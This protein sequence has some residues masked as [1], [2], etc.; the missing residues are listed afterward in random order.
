MQRMQITVAVVTL[1][2][3]ALLAGA[4]AAHWPFWRRAWQWQ[5]AAEGWADTLPGPTV[6]IAAGGNHL[7][8]RIAADARL[9]ERVGGVRRCCWWGKPLALW[10][11]GSHPVR[12]ISR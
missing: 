5:T 8:L 10:P 6:R 12:T 2:V 3:V 9:A 11:H 7:P 4:M 1:V